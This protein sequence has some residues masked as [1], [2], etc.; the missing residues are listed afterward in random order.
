MLQHSSK[1]KKK[2][3]KS[4]GLKHCTV[5]LCQHK[6]FVT[7]TTKLHSSV[8]TAPDHFKISLSNL[9]LLGYFIMPRRTL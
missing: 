5:K 3:L 6:H 9:F 4:N 1:I 2:V 7:S 8:S